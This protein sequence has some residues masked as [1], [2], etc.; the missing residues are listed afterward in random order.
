M[1]TYEVT[2]KAILIKSLTVRADNEE[3]AIEIAHENFDLHHQEGVSEHFD[4]HT[5]SA[6]LLP[7]GAE[8]EPVFER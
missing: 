3:D 6:K 1:K 7:D 2:I 8:T 4:Q 5:E